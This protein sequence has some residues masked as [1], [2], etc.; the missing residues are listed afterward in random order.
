MAWGRQQTAGAGQGELR[1]LT[2]QQ[3]VSNVTSSETRSIDRSSPIPFYYQLQEILKEEIERG[4]WGPGDLLPSEA[5]LEQ[6]FGVSRTVIR[7]ALDVL[8]AD[9][10]ITR[11][12]GRR[13]QVA[14]P[15]FRWEATI[16]ARNWGHPGPLHRVLL[17]QLIDARRVAAGGHV[18]R[19]LNVEAAAQVFELTYTQEV[20]GHPVA[21]SQMYLRLDASPQLAAACGQPGQLPVLLEG[22]PDVPD[23][24]ASRYCIEVAASQATVELT[25]TNEFEASTLGVALGSPVFLLSTL[26]LGP[27]QAPLAFTRAVIRGDQFRFSL[28]LRRSDAEGAQPGAGLMAFMAH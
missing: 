26:D 10:Q 12:K 5:D 4:T 19:L 9:G 25:R 23:Q 17:G 22:G 14:E 21:L 1:A 27:A 20:N 15:K 6:R 28:V 11:G 24:L 7:Q 8:E 13:S 18:G 3:E 16:G 2:G